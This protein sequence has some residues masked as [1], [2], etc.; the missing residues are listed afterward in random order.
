[1]PKGNGAFIVHAELSDILPDYELLSCS[2][3][4]ASIPGL[5]HPALRQ[6]LSRAAVVHLPPGIGHIPLLGRPLRIQTFHSFDVDPANMKEASFAQ[7]VYYR[8][9]LQPAI[10]AACSSADRIVAVSRFV[11]DNIRRHKLADSKI[12]EVIY[13]GVDTCR[14]HPLESQ[15][16]DRPLRI[17]FVGNPTRRKGFHLLAGL[18]EQLPGTVELA[19]TSGLRNERVKSIH[20]RLIS[21]GHVPYSEMHHLYQ[22]A[23]IL[24]FPAYR[25][26]F[27]LCVAEA[28]ACGLPVVSSNC[29]AIPELIDNERGG[30]LVQAGDFSAILQKIRQ[31]LGD[32]PLRRAMGAWN[33]ERAVRDFDRTRMAMEYRSLFD[34]VSNHTR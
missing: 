18:A 25:E 15:N 10:L 5:P 3:Y 23:D 31:L 34:S 2:P 19:F 11:A 13:N 29:S 7:R 8:H 33:R 1:M 6:W 32:A 21:L 27:G 22:Q 28:M 16:Q 4:L 20:N 30:F 17:L 26:G 12:V 14:F 24:L 9:V